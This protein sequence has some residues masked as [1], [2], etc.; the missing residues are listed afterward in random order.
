MLI[1]VL[2][3]SSLLQP[4]EGISRDPTQ[5]E[6]AVLKEPERAGLGVSQPGREILTA[7][8]FY[9]K[10]TTFFKRKMYLYYF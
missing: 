8:T 3:M 6:S 10:K 5:R 9:V 7:N 4:W 2:K 1:W